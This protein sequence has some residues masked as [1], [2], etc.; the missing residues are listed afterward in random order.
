MLAVDA[1]LDRR[2]LGWQGELALSLSLLLHQDG[3]AVGHSV[4]LGEVWSGP[5]D[6]TGPK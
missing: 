5:G 2:E 3:G 4:E 1:D 6:T